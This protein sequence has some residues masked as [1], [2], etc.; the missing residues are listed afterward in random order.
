VG[1]EVKEK[2]NLSLYL[3]MKTDWRS[4]RIFPLIL[5]LGTS[6]GEWSASHPWPLHPLLVGSHL[7]INNHYDPD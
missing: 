4:G 1:S 3:S 7:F 6:W 2:V 5:D